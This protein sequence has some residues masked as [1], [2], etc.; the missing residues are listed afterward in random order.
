MLTLL[1][2]LVINK[3]DFCGSVMAGATD[4]LLLR[5][6]SVLNAAVRLAFSARKYDHTTPLLR[7]LHWLKVP[8]RVKFRLCV[9][10]YR[11]LNGTVPHYLAETIHPVTSRGTRQRLRSAD[12]STL[13]V[14]PT[15]RTTL[16]DRSFPAAAARAW[17]TLPQQV[18]DAPS[19]PVF[20][21]ELK[22]VLFQ[23][24]FPAD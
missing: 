3:L 9:L 11:C 12:T 21:R 1:R 16:G 2:S 8:E 10:T 20:R 18:Q 7:K 24:S 19:L 15:R 13:L 6:Q 22:T 23:S 17:N 5:L 14:P 4:V